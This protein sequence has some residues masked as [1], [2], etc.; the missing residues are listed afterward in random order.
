M[1]LS[2]W[3]TLVASTPSGRGTQVDEILAQILDLQ[4][5]WT[6]ENTE[7]MQL[8]GELVRHEGPDWLREHGGAIS[9]AIGIPLVDLGF[10]GRDGTGR[11]TEV[12][13]FR[14]YSVSRSPSATIGWYC[15]FLFDA[16]GGTAYLTVG[17][18]STDWTGSEFRPRPESDLRQMA[19]WARDKVAGTSVLRP[20][21]MTEISLNSR[22]SNLG[23]SYEAG[24]ALAFG[25]KRD[26][27]PNESQILDDVVFMAG[28]LGQVY[29]AADTETVPGA[30][31]PEVEE[32]LEVSDK[33]AGKLPKAGQGFRLS[34]EE[35]RVVE[36][37]AVELAIDHLKNLG[38]EKISDVGATKSFDLECKTGDKKLIVEVKGTTSM[39]DQIVLTRNEVAIHKDLY[40]G[41]ALIQV[42]GIKLEKLPEGPIASGGELSMRH[43]WIVEDDR[44]VPVSY[45]Y[46][47][48]D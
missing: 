1:A 30:M 8:R 26:S 14:F 39:G 36:L 2:E 5:D 13:W 48:S 28:L 35:R 20:D 29:R 10:E 47:L 22:R 37:R 34:A 41:N 9:Q 32:L 12:P 38:W 18:G 33:A 46:R 17:H 11:K 40:P 16:E 6:S 42:T 15:V 43:P 7:E 25:Y 4:S 31:P 44:L 23:P 24:T 27:L 3:P 45:M 21:L 19:G